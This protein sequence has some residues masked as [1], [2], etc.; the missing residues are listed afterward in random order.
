MEINEMKKNLRRW[1]E[2]ASEFLAEYYEKQGSFV[3]KRDV[4][5]DL[6][7]ISR[8]IERAAVQRKRGIDSVT[9]MW[10]RRDEYPE[11]RTLLSMI[12]SSDLEICLTAHDVA[13]HTDDITEFATTN[14]TDFVDDGREELILE[15][16]ELDEIVDL[17]R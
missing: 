15:H 6:R 8:E 9:E 12:H 1:D 2:D 10:T 11:L 17:A 16:T 3:A 5:K 4:L 13:C 7:N 14:P